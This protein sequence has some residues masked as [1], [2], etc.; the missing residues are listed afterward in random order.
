MV[1]WP[2]PPPPPD[3]MP[4]VITRAEV[5]EIRAARELANMIKRKQEA[6]RQKELDRVK[7]KDLIIAFN[8]KVA[9]TDAGDIVWVNTYYSSPGAVECAKTHIEKNKEFKYHDMRD[10]ELI[11]K[12][13]T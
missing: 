4:T 3:T 7:C 5:D 2:G 10:G 1:L 9:K 13:T 6:I 8:E 12:E 11:F